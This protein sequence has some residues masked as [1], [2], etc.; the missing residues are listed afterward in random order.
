[1]AASAFDLVYGAAWAHRTTLGG[2]VLTVAQLAVAWTL[3]SR[4]PA[5]AVPCRL[6]RVPRPRGPQD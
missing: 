3:M 5:P 4:V 6:D 2:T 1:M